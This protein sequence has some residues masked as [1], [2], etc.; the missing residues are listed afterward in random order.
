MY[1][2]SF[3]YDENA[4]KQVIKYIYRRYKDGMAEDTY[5]VCY[6]NGFKRTY[7]ICT[8]MIHKHFEFIMNAS[9]IKTRYFKDKETGRMTKSE[10]YFA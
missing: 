1:K 10:T 2:R 3:K 8:K 9:D 4:K 6:E 5:L 7:K